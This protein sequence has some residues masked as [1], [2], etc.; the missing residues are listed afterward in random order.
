ML[1]LV[2]FDMSGT[3]VQDKGQ[4]AGAFRHALRRQ[5]ILVTETDLQPWRGAS[6]R[7]VL[8]FFIEEKWG[9]DVPENDQR[10]EQ[11][12]ADFRA[13]LERAY[14]RGGVRAIAG[15]EETFGWLRRQGIKVALTTGF[16]RGVADLIM[17]QLGWTKAI[18]ACISSDEVAQGRPAPYM[19]FRAMEATGVADV[20]RVAKVGDTVLDLQA[21]YNAGAG[22]LAGV[23]SG[24]GTAEQMGRVEGAR[25]IGSVAELPQLM[26]T[27]VAE[28]R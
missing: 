14:A 4:V 5:Q 12:F 27:M 26:E 1:E 2:V 9:P 3:T 13:E 17:E 7:R 11:A 19:I 21:G 16:Y 24:S 6:K 15:T 23:L 20:R 22:L 28:Q 10:V 25:I 8:R 18:E